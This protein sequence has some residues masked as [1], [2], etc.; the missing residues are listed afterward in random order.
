MP[1]VFRRSDGIYY[2]LVNDPDGHRKWV[3]TRSRS[4]PEALK[5]LAVSQAPAFPKQ[6]FGGGSCT[7]AHLVV[8]HNA[9]RG[10]GIEGISDICVVAGVCVLEAIDNRT[11]GRTTCSKRERLPRSDLG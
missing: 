6:H 4:K 5:K 8:K 1:T 3:S 10:I 7:D 9:E 11:D 2:A